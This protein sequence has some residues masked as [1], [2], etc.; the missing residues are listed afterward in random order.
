MNAAAYRIRPGREHQLP[1]LQD[2]ERAAGE[3]FRQFGMHAVA[4]DDPPPPDVLRRH[5]R[6]GH[7]R[8]AEDASGHPAGYLIAEPLDGCLHVEQVSVHPA[9]ARRRIGRALL[10]DAARTA[11]AEGRRALTLT[12]FA[13]VPWNAPYYERCGFRRLTERELTSGLRDVRAR[14]AAA[15]LDRWPRVCMRRE[16]GPSAVAAPE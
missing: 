12:T 5:L 2:L 15:G 1:V 4:D 14:E 3:M 7:L 10:D 9:H 6:A 8:I 13:E 11:A 16:I